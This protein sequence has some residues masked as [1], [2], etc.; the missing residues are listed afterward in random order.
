MQGG[1]NDHLT[2]REVGSVGWQM[3]KKMCSGR[4]K[5]FKRISGITT[6]YV[7]CV[8]YIATITI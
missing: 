3:V 5:V 2:S 1:Y 6:G 8:E 7:Q 4:S